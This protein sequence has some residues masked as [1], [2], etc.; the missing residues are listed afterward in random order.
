MAA[1]AYFFNRQTGEMEW[2]DGTTAQANRVG[3]YPVLG[4]EGG[5]EEGG[6]GLQLTVTGEPQEKVDPDG[7]GMPLPFGGRQLLDALA[8]GDEDR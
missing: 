4:E 6:G 2:V 1:A 3:I 5:G 7:D 8:L